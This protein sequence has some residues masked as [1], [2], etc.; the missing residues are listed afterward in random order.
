MPRHDLQPIASDESVTE[1]ERG[2]QKRRQIKIKNPMNIRT[3]FV[4]FLTLLLL[5]IATSAAKPQLGGASRSLNVLFIATDD[6]NDWIGCM[7]GHPQVKTPN[8]D[9]LA[10]RG[11]LFLNADCQSPLCNPSRTSVMMGLRPSTTGV[12]SLLPAFRAQILR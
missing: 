9:K 10:S 4:A 6:L 2:S 1:L 8:L 7:G 12:Y 11:T 3:L 5:P